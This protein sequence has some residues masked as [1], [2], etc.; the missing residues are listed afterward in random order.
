MPESTY[1]PDPILLFT[2]KMLKSQ[3][4]WISELSSSVAVL[5]V[6]VRGLD[7]TFDDVRE[8]KKKEIE[9]MIAPKRQ[10]LLGLYDRLLEAIETGDTSRL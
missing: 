7:P 1:K 9:E 10:E 4:R 6:S 2:A 5:S 8:E 3:A